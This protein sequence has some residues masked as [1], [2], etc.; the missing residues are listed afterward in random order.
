MRGMIHVGASSWTSEAWWGRVYP[1]DLPDGERIHWYSRLYDCVEVDSTYYAVPAQRMVAR[2]AAKTPES[3]RFTLKLTRDFLD[4]KKPVD[5]AALEDFF[6][7]AEALG[8]KLSAVLLQFPPWVKPGRAS[9]RVY[10]LLDQL[11]GKFRY[12]LELRDAGWFQE[13]ERSKLLAELERRRVALCWSYLTYVAIPP[14][15]TTDFL[16]LRF[17]G[18][19]TTVPPEQH[20]EIRVDRSDAIQ[21]WAGRLESASEGIGEAFAFF[22]N[23]FAGFAPASMNQFRRAVGLPE[24]AYAEPLNMR[25]LNGSALPR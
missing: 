16:Y 17:I 21:L 22:N 5:A 3:F 12:A 23:H 13:G 1:R 10:G 14:E 7:S 18:D 11:P 19:H 4:P 2:W 6:R 24:I 8:T 9:D 25:T 20:G 15:E